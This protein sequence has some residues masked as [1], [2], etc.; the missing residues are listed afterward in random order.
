MK[1]PRSLLPIGLAAAALSATA[2]GGDDPVTLYSGRGEDLVQPVVDSCA[3]STGLDIEVRYGDSAEMLLL[4]QEEGDNSPADVYF[5]QGAGFLGL[6]SADGGLLP[7]DE[8]VLS[9][10]GDDN[11]VSPNRDWVGITGRARTVAYNSDR[12]SADDLPASFAD[13]TDPAWAGRIGWAPTN[14]SFQDHVTALRTLLGEDGARTWLEGI[15]AN[16][17]IAYGGNTQ[18]LEAVAAGEVE[19][20][21]VNHYYLYRFLAEDPDF[22]VANRFY[23]DGDPGA[24]VNVAGAGVLATADDPDAASALVNCLLSNASQRYFAE[25]NFELPVVDSV[26]PWSDLPRLDTLTL[27]AFD[28]NRLADLQGTVD[29]LIEVGAL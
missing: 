5:S 18:V 22:P 17:P 9:R 29:L 13:F 1:F 24:L 21:F 26:E 16:D 15:M 25:A 12:L 6:L 11:L 23:T 3:A 2:C 4:I 14:A 19:V 20:G 7:L 8:S 27:P 28:L 10:V